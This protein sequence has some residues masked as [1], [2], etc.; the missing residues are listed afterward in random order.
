MKNLI[1]TAF[2]FTLLLFILCS[3]AGFAQ[4]THKPVSYGATG[5]PYGYYEYLPLDYKDKGAKSPLLIFLHGSGEKGNGR[6]KGQLDK[7]V[8][9]GPG[10]E[11]NSGKHLPFVILSPQTPDWWNTQKLNDFIDH[12]IRNYNID[13]DRIYLTGLSMGAM[14]IFQYA[15]KHAD[16]IAGIVAIAGSGNTNEVCNYSSVPLWTFHG[17]RDTTVPISGSQNVVNTYNNCNPKPKV[18]AKLTV[19]KGYAHWGWNEVYNGKNGDIYSWLLQ[20]PEGAK[21]QPKPQP[22]PNKAPVVNAGND[23]EVNL[24]V[25]E[26]AFNGSASDKDG[27]IV[28]Y[29]WTKVNGPQVNMSGANTANLQLKNLNAGTYTFRFTAKDNDGASGSDEVR[30]KVNPAPE[31]NEDKGKDNNKDVKVIASAGSDKSVT[32]PV[33]SESLHGSAQWVNCSVRSYKW[34]KVNGPSVKMS[35]K[36][37]AN[38]SLTN[39]QEGEYTFRFTAI[40][41]NGVSG[42]DDVKVRVLKGK[43]AGDVKDDAPVKDDGVVSPAP[44]PATKQGL[45]YS[46]YKFHSGNALKKLP[47]FSKINPDKKGHVSGFSLAPRDKDDYFA[48]AY[49]GYIN[50]SKSGKY[51]FYTLSDDGSKLYINDK[52]VVNNDGRHPEKVKYGWVNLTSGSHKIRVEYFENT[53]SEVLYVSYKGPGIE[54]QAIPE[55]ILSTQGG[56]VVPVVT[57]NGNKAENGLNYS[58]YENDDQRNKWTRLPDFNRLSAAKTGEINNFS[59]AVKERSSHFAL[60]FEGKV[61]ID[62]AGDYTF[63]TNS[64]DGSQLF[65]NG[66][67]VVQNDGWHG[68]QERSGTVNLSAGY[69]DIKVTFYEHEGG[70]VLDV[71]WR[72]PG[73]GKQ[74]VP[75]HVLYKSGNIKNNGNKATARLKDAESLKPALEKTAEFRLYPNPAQS[76]IHLDLGALAE[77]SVIISISDLTGRKMYQ[78]NVSAAGGEG[79]NLELEAIGLRKG[80]YMMTIES[81]QGEMVKAIRFLKD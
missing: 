78:T 29:N 17:D 71:K 41:S 23:R 19:L 12:A 35:G 72:G 45:T 13:K 54:L 5:A 77:E 53:G 64:D 76:Y 14:G 57:D 47:D 42:S 10:R 33:N 9:F 21:P 16:R 8:K 69:H 26:V 39:L 81:Q 11:I 59:L 2:S 3:N 55:S 66:R 60:L 46:Y 52:L 38:L 28:S 6:G 58:Y 31:K 1:S 30:L 63:Y 25:K 48:F 56:G 43:V 50:I 37:T 32:L 44:V 49:D 74:S 27:R 20:Y 61:K 4:G 67:L 73:I 75:D 51:A 15:G 79:I 70:E 22:E 80:A 65:I 36:G 18:K 24:P 40:S 7:A 62:K 68:P 34:E